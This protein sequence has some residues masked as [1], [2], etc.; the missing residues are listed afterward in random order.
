MLVGSFIYKPSQWRA[1]HAKD[2]GL[3]LS[4]GDLLS[5][6]EAVEN[7]APKQGDFLRSL[8]EGELTQKVLKVVHELQ[9]EQR[10]SV[11]L[12]EQAAMALQFPRRAGSHLEMEDPALELVKSLCRVLELDPEV[13][14]E[15]RGPQSGGAGVL[16]S[17]FVDVAACDRR[18]DSPMGHDA[19]QTTLS[20]RPCG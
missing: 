15:A 6:G 1:D 18:V 8:V 9:Q 17:P 20:P 10:R 12:G 4:Q 7:E 3:G 2:A 14:E 19:A 5:Q 16:V 11:H 13:K